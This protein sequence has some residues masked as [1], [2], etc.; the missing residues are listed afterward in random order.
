MDFSTGPKS[1]VLCSLGSLE[2]LAILAASLLQ[3]VSGAAR[4]A[5]HSSDPKEYKTGF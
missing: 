4:I 2:C 5:R 3:Q 1:S